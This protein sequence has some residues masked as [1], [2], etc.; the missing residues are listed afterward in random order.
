[1]FRSAQHVIRRSAQAAPRLQQ[2]NATAGGNSLLKSDEGPLSTST[3]HKVNMLIMG[4]TPLAFALSPSII[5]LPVDL[6]LGLA[7]PLHA[8]IGMSYVITDYVPKLSKGLMGPA[9]VALLGLTGVTTVGLLKVNI[10]GEGMTE[11]VKSLWRGK[12]A[13]ED[14]RK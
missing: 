9:R 2:R 5:N 8:H 11:T 14:R 7:L 1:M 6:L 13:V 3:Y 4:L 12:K 10:M